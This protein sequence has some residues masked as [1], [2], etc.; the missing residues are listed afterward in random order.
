MVAVDSVDRPLHHASPVYANAIRASSGRTVTQLW[1]QDYVACLVCPED[2]LNCV[3]PT[4]LNA[5]RHKEQ[6]NGLLL[7]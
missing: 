5:E 1:V 3:S 6:P 7:D 4:S 2:S